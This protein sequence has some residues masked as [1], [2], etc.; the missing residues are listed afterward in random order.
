MNDV[1][2]RRGLDQQYPQV[3]QPLPGCRPTGSGPGSPSPVPAGA[4]SCSDQNG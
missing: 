4:G 1:T 3:R 2:Q